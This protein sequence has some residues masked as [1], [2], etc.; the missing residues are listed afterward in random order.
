MEF[1][2]ALWS[3]RVHATVRELNYSARKYSVARRPE[4]Y[5]MVS[6]HQASHVFSCSANDYSDRESNLVPEDVFAGAKGQQPPTAR[7]ALWDI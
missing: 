7:Q 3:P 1:C 2:N 4:K 5:S 6:H